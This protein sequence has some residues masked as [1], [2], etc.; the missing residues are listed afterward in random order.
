VSI[1]LLLLGAAAAACDSAEDVPEETSASPAISGVPDPNE[2]LARIAGEVPGFAGY[3]R[4]P[5]VSN[6]FIVYST[7]PDIDVE[8][9]KL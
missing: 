1:A 3:S 9:S 4:D 6:G 2:L 7:T 5:D 8:M